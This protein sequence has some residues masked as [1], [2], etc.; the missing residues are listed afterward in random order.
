MNFEK[1]SS[2][3]II[4]LQN[5]FCPDGH[6]AV[7]GGDQIIEK[8]NSLQT[9]FTSIVLTQDWHP[10]DHLSFASNQDDKAPYETIKMPYG[11]QVLW[12]D[13]CIQ[14]TFGAEFHKDLD[15]SKANIIVRKGYRKNIDSYSAFYENDRLTM[16]GLDGFLKQ[17]NIKKVYICGLALDFCV[18]YSAIDAK[19]L[20]F[21]TYVILNA[22]KAIDLDGS[23][24]KAL[25]DMESNG[26]HLV[27]L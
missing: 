17:N 26:V 6:L 24:H 25:Q 14:G 3:I 20:G 23:K 18:Y 2:L 11:V 16:T 19:N 8:I 27:N 22:T 15:T 4:D 12:P 10:C 9:F 1:D 5:D 13:H 21:E 7:D